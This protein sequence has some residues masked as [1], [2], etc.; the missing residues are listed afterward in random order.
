M[1]QTVRRG[2]NGGVTMAGL[3]A[4]AA[5]GSV[6]GLTFVILGFITTTCTFDI[7][8]KQL[9]LIPVSALAGLCGSL[10]DSLLGA[11]LQY[12]GF[13]SVRNKVIFRLFVFIF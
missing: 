8:L 7:A 10:I 9:L 12:S 1:N 2:T 4:A 5:G 11:T 6:L 13:C 3:L